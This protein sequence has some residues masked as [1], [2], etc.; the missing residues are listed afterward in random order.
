M[1]GRLTGCDILIVEDEFFILLDLTMMFEKLGASVTGVA[2]LAEAMEIAGGDQAFSAAVLDVRLPD[3]EV[4]PAAEALTKRGIPVIFHS[5]HAN[6][7]EIETRFPEALALSKPAPETLL[8][9]AVTQR[10]LG[11]DGAQARAVG[12]A[13]V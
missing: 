9:D 4:F 11:V 5:G 6:T 10:M 13:G 3:G 2:S 8:V 7:S 12:T 1:D